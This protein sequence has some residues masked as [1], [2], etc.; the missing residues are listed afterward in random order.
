MI[1]KK[2][3]TKHIQELCVMIILQVTFLNLKYLKNIPIY[4][5]IFIKPYQQHSLL[6]FASLLL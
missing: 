2:N 3:V 6:S 5:A 4:N 1:Y